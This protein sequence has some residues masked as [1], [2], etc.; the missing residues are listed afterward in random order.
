MDKLGYD[1]KKPMTLD[2][3]VNLRVASLDEYIQHFWEYR[4]VIYKRGTVTDDLFSRFD[5]LLI[6]N[7]LD[8]ICMNPNILCPVS[9]YKVVCH[10]AD[11]KNDAIRNKA[12]ETLLI[13]KSTMSKCVTVECIQGACCDNFM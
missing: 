9:Y 2:T 13:C 11:R 10:M 4:G 1:F 12:Y 5:D 7:A 6:L 8:H 3:T